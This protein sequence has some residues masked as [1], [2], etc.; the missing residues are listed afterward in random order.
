[1]KAAI[2]EA[3]RDDADIL[4][5]TEAGGEG[6]NLQF[7]SL[8]VNFNLPW[9]PQRVEQRIGRVHRY[10]QKCDVV[11]VNFINRSNRADERVF[12]LLQE[13]FA[14]FD[15]VF[16]ASD[17]TLGALESGVDIE[18]RILEIYQKCRTTEEVEAAFD[19]LQTEMDE[20]LRERD[21]E[22]RAKL[23]EHFDEDVAARLKGRREESIANL[24]LF[25]RR[26]LALVRAEWPDA[27]VDG[28]RII[29][30]GVSYTLDRR[31]AEGGPARFFRLGLPEADALVEAAKARDLPRHGFPSTLM[32]IR[33]GWPM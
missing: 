32:P 12:D 11:V 24:D 16:G 7:C 28:H 33:G 27:A 10:G 26:L 29:R 13:K 4:I 17:E 15:G 5:A 6:V 3:F 25:Q 23:I 2:V 30:D 9:N 18:R 31:E 1:M 14:L 21:A 8:L 20:L 19:L 22:T